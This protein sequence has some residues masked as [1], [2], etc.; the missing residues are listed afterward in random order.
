LFPGSKK[1]EEKYLFFLKKLLN[2]H[3]KSHGIIGSGGTESNISAVWLAKKLNPFKNELIIPESAH[4]S[5]KKIASIMDIK[6]VTIKLNKNYQL[7]INEVKKKINSNTLGVVGIAG[8][9]ELGIVDPIPELSNI[10]Q[11]NNLF[12]H[13]DAAFGGYII[14]F[15]EKLGYIIPDFDFRNPGVCSITIDAHK[16]G[17]STIPLG[18]L[19]FRN[20]EWL[21][22]ISVDTPYISSIRQP[23]ILATRSAAPVAA[24]YA[25]S[26]YLGIKGYTD[27]V[28]KC[29]NNTFYI[30]KRLEEIGLKLIT[31]PMMNVIAIK[32][33]NPTKIVRILTKKGYK[34]NKIDRLSSIRIVIMPHVTKQVIDK[35]IPILRKISKETDEI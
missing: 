1:I 33:K 3:E 11:K 10:C 26:E 23:G 19:I 12:L 2:A 29:M 14:P 17:C 34:I 7:D 18:S 8:S 31:E 5:F 9:T 27:L 28:D 13:V 21:E 15:L 20:R 6:L 25:V 30:V 16:M 22:K 32:L 4:F 35:F 24:A